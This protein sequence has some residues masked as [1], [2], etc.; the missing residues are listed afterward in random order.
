MRHAT[1]TLVG[2]S[3]HSSS[4][5]TFCAAHANAPPLPHPASPRRF[6]CARSPTPSMRGPPSAP[7]C[8]SPASDG[9]GQSAWAANDKGKR[10]C[11]HDHGCIFRGTQSVSR[12]GCSAANARFDSVARAHAAGATKGTAVGGGEWWQDTQTRSA[13]HEALQRTRV[14]LNAPVPTP[15][16]VTLRALRLQPTPTKPPH[17]AR[18]RTSSNV[19]L[20]VSVS[21]AA[22]Q[23]RWRSA[24]P[25][26]RVQSALGGR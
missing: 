12:S 5:R 22:H 21:C 13:G 6:A 19:T 20:G 24:Q 7:H 23:R 11:N 18:L 15:T 8:A 14:Q 3:R 26:A 9:A 2:P 25:R 1:A 10:C 17:P 16:A 4:Y